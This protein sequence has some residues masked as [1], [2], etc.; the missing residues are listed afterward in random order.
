MHATVCATSELPL[1]VRHRLEYRL[2]SKEGLNRQDAKMAVDAMLEFFAEAKISGKSIVP[3]KSADKAWHAFILH[4]PE[5]QSFC[6]DY[7]GRYLH[8]LPTWPPRRD[9]HDCVP[10][11]CTC[12]GESAK[13][14]HCEGGGGESGPCQ[15]TTSWRF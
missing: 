5:Y 15:A 1:F 10:D 12:T 6:Q 14:A 8:H 3:N 9:N 7:F 2:T 4:T 13:L 11:P